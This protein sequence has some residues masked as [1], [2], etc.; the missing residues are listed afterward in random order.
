MLLAVEAA[1]ESHQLVAA[2]VKLA[3]QSRAEVL[4]LSVRE[5]DY[6]RGFVW[7]VRPAGEVAEVVSQ[8]L[9][10]LQRVNVPA[11]GVV[12]TA[13]IGKVA[14]EIIY[15]AEKHGVSEIVIGI[16]RRSWFA[17][18]VGGCVSRQ[19]LRRSPIP[20]VAIAASAVELPTGGR[21]TDYRSATAPKR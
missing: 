20:V 18:L 11:R 5:R 10:E 7:D 14:Q 21:V 13:R 4:V 12:A 8:A 2:A 17:R 19:I 6:G 16:P 9:Y 1:P 3:V 15:F